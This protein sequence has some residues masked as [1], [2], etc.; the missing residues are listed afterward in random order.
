MDQHANNQTERSSL[1]NWSGPRWP[2]VYF[3]MRDSR[4]SVPKQIPLFGWTLSLGKGAGV[5]WLVGFMLAIA[6]A[7]VSVAILVAVAE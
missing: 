6:L 7:M 3:S 5:A 1:E 4:V 2:S